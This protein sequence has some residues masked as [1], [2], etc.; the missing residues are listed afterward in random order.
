MNPMRILL[1]VLLHLVVLLPLVA[2][3]AGAQKPPVNAPEAPPSSPPEGWPFWGGPRHDFTSTSTGLANEWPKAGPRRLWSRA[4]GDG[5]SPIAEQDGVLYTAYRRGDKD[6][7]IALEAETGN[8]L[9]E[10]EY[11]APFRNAYSEAVGP[12]PYAMPQIVGDRV[13][14]AS[15]SGQIHSLDKKT[16]RPVWSHDV[17]R[18]FGGTRLEYGYSCHALPYKD[19]LIYLVGGKAPLFG[20]GR[21]SAVVA[22]RRADGAVA[23]KNLGFVNA[24]SSPLLIDVGG[25]PQVVALLADEVIGFSPEDGA[26]RWRHPH[27][28]DF[29]LA[30]ATPLWADENRLFVSSAYGS[31]TRVLELSRNGVDT[32]VKQL[33]HEARLQLHFGS[34]IRV[35]EH[36]YFSSG[37][38]GPAFVSAV[39][40]QTGRIAWQ[41]REFAKAQL[42]LADGKL[43]LLDED[44]T[45]ALAKATPERF[46]VLSRVSLLKRLAWTPPTLV[47]THLFVR[48]RAEIMALE[49]GPAPAKAAPLPLRKR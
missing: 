21:G 41:S 47:G 32:S 25:E 4:L 40:L 15:G 9:W 39:E 44:G 11:A 7:V 19:T 20:F 5:Y 3:T 27:R 37:H 29:G 10:H 24:H 33:W 42:L 34:A 36:V 48:D 6:V 22:L 46:Q 35:G 16:G 45:L 14:S 2:A 1:V 8:T 49:L 12:G 31:G 13:I 30:I 38:R 17:Y 26:L 28:T 43:I 23:W 18:E